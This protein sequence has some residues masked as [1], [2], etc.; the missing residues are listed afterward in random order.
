MT[1]EQADSLVASGDWAQ[2]LAE[3]RKRDQDLDTCTREGAW[4][5]SNAERLTLRHREE[6]DE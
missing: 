6:W 2:A 3:I 5:E 4:Q 1:Q